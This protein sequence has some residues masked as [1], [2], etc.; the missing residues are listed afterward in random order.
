MKIS[1]N[2]LNINASGWDFIEDKRTK[3]WGGRVKPKTNR[4]YRKATRRYIKNETNVIHRLCILLPPYLSHL[5]Y[6]YIT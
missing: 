2:R 5:K 4:M 6:K 3:S 1:G